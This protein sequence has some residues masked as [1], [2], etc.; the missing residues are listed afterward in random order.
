MSTAKHMTVAVALVVI[1]AGPS[2]SPYAG[3]FAWNADTS[4]VETWA[5]T[6]S[7]GGQISG[8]LVTSTWYT[9]GSLSGRVRDDGRYSFTKSVTGP[10]LDD[11]E[12]GPTRG[13]NSYTVR[14]DFDGLLET[15]AAGNLVGNGFTWLRP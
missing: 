8:S 9:K 5:V 12:R 6:I 14:T 10:T 4:A 1:G 7:D 3:T 13:P 2:K 15:D 11:P